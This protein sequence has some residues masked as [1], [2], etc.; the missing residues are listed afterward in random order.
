MAVVGGRH[1]SERLLMYLTS[2]A[3]CVSLSN[4]LCAWYSSLATVWPLNLR[5]SVLVISPYFFAVLWKLGTDCVLKSAIASSIRSIL[6]VL[7]NFKV[8]WNFGVVC[9]RAARNLYNYNAQVVT[10]S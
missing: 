1:L 9:A 10:T 2:T 4:R 6:V 8:V 7:L 3:S 5:E